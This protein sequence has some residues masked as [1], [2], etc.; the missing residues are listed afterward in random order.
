[1][2]KLFVKKLTETALVPTRAYACEFDGS[3][4]VHYQDAGCDLYSDEDIQ[5]QPL[6]RVLVKTGIAVMIPE[7]C[8]GRVAPRSGLSYKSELDVGAGV[9]D[10]DYRGEVMVCL[11][12]AGWKPFNVKHGMKIAQLVCERVAYPEIVC[13]ENLDIT[14]RGDKGF[15]SSGS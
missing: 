6:S 2:E 4:K 14:V 3:T 11:I 9:I 1:M 15:G 5:I 12:N 13:V 8:Y 10:R 7:G